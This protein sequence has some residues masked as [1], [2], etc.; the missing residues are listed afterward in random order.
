M[1]ILTAT[2]WEPGSV[3]CCTNKGYGNL[4]DKE[5]LTSWLSGSVKTIKWGH[6]PPSHDY[7][8]LNCHFHKCTLIWTQLNPI[9]IESEDLLLNS[10]PARA[11][12][13][14]PIDNTSVEIESVQGNARTQP[15]HLNAIHYQDMQGQL[16][17]LWILWLSTFFPTDSNRQTLMHYL[18]STVPFRYSRKCDQTDHCY[19]SRKKWPCCF[20]LGSCEH[21]NSLSN[22]INSSSAAYVRK[23]CSSIFF[24][25]SYN[26]LCYY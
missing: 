12:E 24:R 21:L 16:F 26:L 3:Y 1:L 15:K 17:L 14:H 25:F 4:A 2:G 20:Q 10:H 19:W 6:C 9:P 18:P 22:T 8:I 13:K 5:D 11:V 23:Y 7:A